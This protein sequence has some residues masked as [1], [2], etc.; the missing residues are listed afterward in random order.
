MKHNFTHRPVLLKQVIETFN[1]LNNTKSPFFVDG[2]VG[3]GGHSV[4]IV[5][6]LKVESRKLKVVG[7]DKDQAALKI[8][9]EK[10]TS[11]K[12][13]YILVNDAFENI[14]QILS[15]NQ[16]QKVDGILLDLGVSSMQLDDKS[17]GFSFKE[18]APLDM[19]MNPEQKLTAADVVNNYRE[20]DLMHLF[21][22]YGEE[23]F[24]KG[25]ANQIVKQRKIKPITTTTQLT[26]IILDVIPK[27]LHFQKTHPATNVFRA[28][29]MEVNAEVSKL[30]QGIKDCVAALNTDGRLAII[31]FHSIEDRIVK[32][33]FRELTD[34]CKCSKEI[35]ECICGLKPSI[36]LVNKKP[37]IASS[38]ETKTN[39]RARSAKLRIVEK[40]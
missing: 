10:L 35:P 38:E 20:E 22:N 8:A 21:F 19:R 6:K 16:I 9:E 12:I 32:N 14:K 5:D 4:A 13:D 29:R 36:K 23:K 15:D 24:S 33:T 27:K 3:L 26:K 25:I 39:P 37:I 2:T 18:E 17:R 30:E 1:Y 31:T 7:I 34:P 40:I 11:E 28:L